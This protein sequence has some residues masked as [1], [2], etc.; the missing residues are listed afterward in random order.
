MNTSLLETPEQT[1]QNRKSLGM[2]SAVVIGLDSMQGLQAARILAAHKV[3]VIGIAADRRHPCC[4]T[5][6]CQQIVISPTAEEELISALEELGTQLQQRAVLYP[7]EDTNVLLVSRHRERLEKW[8]HVQLPPADVV[9]MLMDKVSFY[10]YATENDLPIPRTFFI[11]DE[12]TLAEAAEALRYPCVMKPRDSAARR[13]EHKTIHKAFKVYDAEE[14]AAL[15]REYQCWTDCFIVQ[16][17]IVGR[18][19]DLYSCN[20]YFDAHSEPLVTFTARKI[21]QW[22]PETGISSL[23]E[24]CQNDVVLETALR[25]FKA[26]GF[27][28]LGYLEMKFDRSIGEYF[29]VEPNI[30]RPTG[31]SAIAEAG[32]VEL[33]YTM[34]CDTV[35]LPLPPGRVQKYEGVKWIHVRKDLQSAFQYWKRGELTLA[36]WWRSVRGRKAYALGC[37][38]DPMPFVRDWLHAFRSVLSPTR[39]KKRNPRGS[40]DSSQQ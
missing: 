26:V 34:Y 25:L 12:A 9:E 14:L 8:Y 29:I 22:P 15:Y 31:R 1:A 21:R 20:C 10:E 35:G 32:G 5:N 39:R 11:R 17:W 40:V 23:G 6:V 7:C 37:W 33:L 18:D 36:Q 30:G 27:R 38:R 13:W 28:G 3:P 19:S 16:E 24:E 4:S 2:P